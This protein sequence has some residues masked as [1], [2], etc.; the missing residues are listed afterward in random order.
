MPDARKHG[1]SQG[2]NRRWITRAVAVPSASAR[3]LPLFSNAELSAQDPTSQSISGLN[4][5]RY[6]LVFSP[7]IM[8]MPSPR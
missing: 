1:A 6:L 7:E 5:L 2:Y 3:V 8:N 4:S